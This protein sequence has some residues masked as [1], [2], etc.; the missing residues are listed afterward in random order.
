[1]R[2]IEV[3]H[4]LKV[5]PCKHADVEGTDIRISGGAV[6]SQPFK[7]LQGCSSRCV[8]LQLSMHVRNPYSMIAY[9]KFV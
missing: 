2:S 5:V 9:T 7:W 4:A 3:D 6:A 1:V 8:Q